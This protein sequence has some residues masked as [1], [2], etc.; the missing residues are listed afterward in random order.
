[1]AV[2]HD[3]YCPNAD[4]NVEFYNRLSTEHGT[5]CPACKSGLLDYLWTTNTTRPAAVHE[6]ERAVLYYSEKE[7]KFQYPGR[8][9]RPVPKRLVAR[10][11][12][13]VDMTSAAMLQRHEK[14]HGVAS[15]VLN[16]DRNGRS[17]DGGDE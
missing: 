1:M 5:V 2:I 3:M 4:C 6:R 13:K 11:Y 16:Y 8:N 9:D 10:G 14:Q 12:R 7:G 17:Y 15:H